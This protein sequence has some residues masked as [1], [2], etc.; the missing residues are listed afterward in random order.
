M[1]PPNRFLVVARAGDQSLHPQW[2][3]ALSERNWD[4]V[5]SYFGDDPHRFRS[6]GE[7]RMDD[8]GHKWPGLHALLTRDRFW[9]R[10]DYIWFAD[11]D[12]AADQA[13]ISRLFE[14]A[15]GLGLMLAQPALS[16]TSYFSHPV[17]IRHP[18]FRVRMTDFV[19]IMAPCFERSFLDACLPTFTENLS[20]W[21]IDRLWPRLLP[22]NSRRCAIIDGIEVT[23][24]RPVGGPTYDRLREGG[25]S[26]RAE[27]QT[28]MRKYG[29]PPGI[30]PRVIAAID[31]RDNFL[32]GSLMNDAAILRE[33][34]A[35]DW[36]AFQGARR[37]QDA[38]D[39]AQAQNSMD[40]GDSRSTR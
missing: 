30:R 23:H 10:Y 33:L 5:V 40:A 2:T 29:I 20:G 28:L 31:G 17:T 16:W 32:D 8:K 15:A 6:S 13:S 38:L 26:A 1:V 14:E 9:Q 35:R 7:I 36:S 22:W 21:G 24:T 37:R 18:S 25:I 3:S 12:L 4:L 39:A 27:Y 34:L 11:D 19:E